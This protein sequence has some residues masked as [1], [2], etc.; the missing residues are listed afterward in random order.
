[1]LANLPEVVRN[2]D[3]TGAGRG[4]IRPSVASSRSRGG[5][6]GLFVLDSITSGA[7][8][9]D[10]GEVGVYMLVGAPQK[11]WMGTPCGTFAMS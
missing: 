8:W 9:A 10:M 2:A 11:G 5:V 7:P 4:R 3:T 6:D 1:M